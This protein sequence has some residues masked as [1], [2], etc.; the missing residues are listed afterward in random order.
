MKSFS[1]QKF[2]SVAALVALS[3]F[4][5]SGP[6]GFLLVQKTKP[7]PAWVSPSVFVEHYHIIQDIPYYF[8]FLL[9]GGIIMLVASHY[10]D[11]NHEAALTKFYML[12]SLCLVII[13]SSLI[14]F[15]YI[16]QILFIRNLALNYKPEY[17]SAI[18]TFS[19]ANPLSF[20][21]SNEMFGYGILGCATAL[22]SAYYR[23]KNNFIRMLMIANG[24]ISLAGIVLTILDAGWVMSAAGFVGYFAWN[25]LMIVMMTMMY[26][27][28]SKH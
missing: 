10:L 3:G 15:N 8:G 4:V 24:L 16:C 23:D 27:Y 19:M 21:W 18:E 28:S 20:C 13:F 5:L 2:A 25:I 1:Y 12:L 7:Q 14:F 22:L 11:S 9:I 26:R 6:V 17:D